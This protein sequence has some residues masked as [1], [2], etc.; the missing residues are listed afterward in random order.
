MFDNTMTRWRTYS[1]FGALFLAGCSSAPKHIPASEFQRRYQESERQTL[2]WYA[3]VGET[4]GCI[5]VSRKRLP[6]LFGSK[7]KEQTL[8]TETNGLPADFLHHVRTQP[9]VEPSR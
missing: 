7:P 9:R 2:E 3:Y 1:I 8:F 4:N 6:L 5:Y